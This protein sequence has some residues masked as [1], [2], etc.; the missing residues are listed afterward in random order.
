MR[1]TLV[2]LCILLLGGCANLMSAPT[3]RWP[4]P[5]SD[6]TK[7]CEKDKCTAEE[8]RAAYVKAS[9]FCRNVHNYYE[10]GGRRANNTKLAISVTGSLAGA[11]IAPL[12]SLKAAKAW[13]GLSGA[14]NAIQ[15]TFDESFSSSIAV[16]RRAFVRAAYRE[17]AELFDKADDN[18]KKVET[19]V[20]MA[21]DCA[22]ASARADQEALQSPVKAL[23]ER[24]EK[25]TFSDE[26][27]PE[28]N[29]K[30]PS[31]PAK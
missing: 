27:R 3:P 13:A 18:N 22:M 1:V 2:L 11:V 9:E 4:W 8:A 25:Q 31:E 23:Q 17:G 24:V 26:K 16:N 14:T 12:A 5:L 19:A 15:A 29:S 30:S 7:I 6:K 20:K 10:Y 28:P 21:T